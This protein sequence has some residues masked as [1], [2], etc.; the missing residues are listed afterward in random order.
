MIRRLLTALSY[1]YC[2]HCGWWVKDC[3]HPQD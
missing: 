3:G 1:D 2:K